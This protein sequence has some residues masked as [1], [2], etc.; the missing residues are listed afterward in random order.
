[1]KFFCL[2]N[3]KIG[4]KEKYTQEPAPTHLSLSPLSSW[5]TPKASLF[6][7]KNIKNASVFHCSVLRLDEAQ[8]WHASGHSLL[9]RGRLALL[10]LS[11]LSSCC[12]SV[13]RPPRR[14]SLSSRRP[15]LLPDLCRAPPPGR[16]RVC[17]ARRFTLQCRHL[18]AVLESLPTA[19]AGLSILSRAWLPS[20]SL[21]F[22]NAA[23]APASP[24]TDEPLPFA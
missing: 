15:P 13:A 21:C 6:S 18:A 20:T 1:M 12:R 22:C 16:A 11:S 2:S 7:Q 23:S 9:A 17:A 5:H 14:R 4:K 10:C 19:T 8:R 3:H 24:D